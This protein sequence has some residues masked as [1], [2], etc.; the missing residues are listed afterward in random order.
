MICW[1]LVLTRI[2]TVFQLFVQVVT[3]TCT[4]I[5]CEIGSL[6]LCLCVSIVIFSVVFDW[7]SLRDFSGV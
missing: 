6:G 4:G 7:N 1:E 3:S 5:L 2:V